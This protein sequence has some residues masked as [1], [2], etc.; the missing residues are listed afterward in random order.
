MKIKVLKLFGFILLL[1]TATSSCLEKKKAT[2]QRPNIIFIMS[3]DHAYQAI[4]AYGDGLNRTPNIDLLAKE[5]M[6]FN[7][8]FVNNSLCAPSR[9]A[10]LTGKYSNLNGIKGNGNEVFDGSQETFPKLLHQAGYQTAMIGKW[11]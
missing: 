8:A 9:A 3:D 7:R 5:G 11:H 1:T 4:S 6:I 10:I 2:E